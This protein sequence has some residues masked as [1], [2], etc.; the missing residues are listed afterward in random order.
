VQGNSAEIV[1]QLKPII[2]EW[3]DHNLPDLIENTVK[4]EISRRAR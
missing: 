3:M 2:R 4:R 1:A